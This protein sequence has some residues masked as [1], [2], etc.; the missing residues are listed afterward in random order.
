MEEKFLAVVV[1]R[2]EDFVEPSEW[3]VRTFTYKDGVLVKSPSHVT[4]LIHQT[5][6]KTFS[7]QM[8]AHMRYGWITRI[9]TTSSVAWLLEPYSYIV[10]SDEHRRVQSFL[11]NAPIV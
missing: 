9:W 8:V 1:L 4:W 6:G 11:R 2:R 5:M 7:E 3:L 10:D